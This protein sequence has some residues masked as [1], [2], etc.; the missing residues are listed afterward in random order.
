MKK[1]LIACVAS[2]LLLS[3]CGGGTHDT[4]KKLAVE[5]VNVMLQ[6]NDE[7]AKKTFIQNNVLPEAQPIM[8]LAMNMQSDK[9]NVISEPEVVDAVAQE[10]GVIVL[11][12]G[13]KGDGSETE[14]LV[15]FA[16]GKVIMAPSSDPNNEI[17]KQLREKFN[18]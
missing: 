13:K 12:R 9:S 2:L 6:G 16:E 18:K 4:E 1:F 11:L 5:Y 14:Q 10:K 15:V 7:E 17:Y 3:G 8:T